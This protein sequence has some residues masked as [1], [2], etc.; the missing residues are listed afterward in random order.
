MNLRL[1]ARFAALMLLTVLVPVLA[2]CGSTPAANTSATSATSNG[3]G[4][5][6]TTAPAATDAATA[7][8]ATA[9][10]PATAEATTAAAT[11]SSETTTAATMSSET[12]TATT[13]TGAAADTKSFLV[14]GGSGEPDTLDVLATTA[15]TALIVG[16]QML[17][18]LVGTVPGKFE[19][20]PSLATKWTPNADSTEWTFN[21]RTGVKFHDGT[22]FNADAVVFNFTRMAEHR[23]ADKK[24]NYDIFPEIFGGYASDKGTTWKGVTKVDDN[25]VKFSFTQPTPLFPNYISA[26]YFGLSSPTAVN[27]AAEKYGTTEVGVVGTGPFKFLEWKAGESVTAVRNDDYWGPKA[28][29]PGIVFRTITDQAAR[30]T[31]LKNQ[32]IDFTVNLAPDTRE[33]L[34]SDPN[35]QLVSVEPFNIAYLAVDTSV[36]PLDNPKVRQAIAYAINK[37]AILSGFYGDEGEVAT[38]FLPPSLKAA[39]PQ[40]VET[41][42]YNVDKAKQLLKEAGVENG[43]SSITLT[44]TSKMDLD[45]WYMPVSRPYFPTPEPIAGQI[46]SDL[47]KVGIKVKQVTEDWAVYLKNESA[48]K[49]H[50]L[51]MLGWTGDYADPNNFLQVHFAS[52]SPNSTHYANKQVD[53]LLSKAGSATTADAANKLFQQAGQ[54]INQDLPRIPIVHAPPVYGALKEVQGWV[55]N[56]TGGDDFSVITVTK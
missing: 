16:D 31:E 51:Y 42:D 54:I 3:A 9:A 56:P 48:G 18:R 20:R 39:R 37:K 28:K 21:L 32:S 1:R 26:G 15:G 34:K 38:D 24:V 5:A 25:T 12:T 43:F 17:E 55:P 36:K 11:M 10:A 50:G 14:Y 4:T 13:T 35:L 53:D 45:L 41:Y 49:K 7:S 33:A 30:L 47:Q 29:M 27:K 23:Y 2:A 40:G 52:S 46:A 22:P 44:D 6:A 19:L 8:Q